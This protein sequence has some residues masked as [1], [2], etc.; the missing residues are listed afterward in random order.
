MSRLFWEPQR[1]GFPGINGTKPPAWNEELAQRAPEPAATLPPLAPSDEP[2]PEEISFTEPELEPL[3]FGASP[4]DPSV[5]AIE[6]RTARKD[7]KEVVSLRCIEG[8]DGTIVECDV[9]PISEMRVEPLRPGPYTFASVREA[10]VFMGEAVR[11]LSYLGCDV[12]ER[13]PPAVQD[14]Q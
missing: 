10:K 8:V 5:R 4:G 2:E 11:A 9:Y 7:G 13:E 3:G 12:P 6:A 14:S 1:N